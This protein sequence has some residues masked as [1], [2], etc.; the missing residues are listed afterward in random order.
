[1]KESL[2]FFI[3]SIADIIILIFFPEITF[4]YQI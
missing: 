2:S 4:S 1:M 3:T